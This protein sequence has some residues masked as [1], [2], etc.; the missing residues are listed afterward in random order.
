M[1][2]L[3]TLAFNT[4]VFLPTGELDE[5]RAIDRLADLIPMVRHKLKKEY[6]WEF[7]ETELRKGLREGRLTLTDH[8]VQAANAGD[9]IA[10]MAL[11]TVYA[12]MAGGVLPE[13]G[14]GHLQVWAYGQRA[15][16]CAPH[17]QRGHSWHDDWIRNIQICQ[18]IDFACREFGVRPTRNRASRRANRAPSGISLVV[19]ALDHNGI[20]LTEANVQ[21][22]FWGG[23]PGELV[24]ALSPLGP[25]HK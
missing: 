3:P 18:L 13:R 12:E 15:V 22:N 1:T 21:E 5:D 6:S 10:D 14:P 23:L 2:L 24:R 25:Y 11:R 16:L 19:A 4:S 9:E 8:A 17:K 7:L 20:H